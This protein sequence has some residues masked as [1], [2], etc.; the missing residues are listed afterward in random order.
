[1]LR[2]QTVHAERVIWEKGA[3]NTRARSTPIALAARGG[4]SENGNSDNYVPCHTAT[5]FPT[6]LGPR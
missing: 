5:E 4:A 2:R 1:M 6:S 3:A